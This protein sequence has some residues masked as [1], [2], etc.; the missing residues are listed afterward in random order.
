MA[1]FEY[2]PPAFVFVLAFGVCGARR[3]GCGGGG[4]RGDWQLPCL[5]QPACSPSVPPHS[6]PPPASS[7]CPSPDGC[8]KLAQVP[9]GLPQPPP[10]PLPLTPGRTLSFSL[11]VVQRASA[12][13]ASIGQTVAPF[14]VSAEP[15][16]QCQR[17]VRYSTHFKFN[18]TYRLYFNA[19]TQS[20][21]FTLNLALH[22]LYCNA[23][24]HIVSISTPHP[25]P[26]PKS[27]SNPNPIVP[28]LTPYPKLILYLK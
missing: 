8:S 1:D 23:W 7:A 12:I 10:L 17:F 22:S 3:G 16:Q 13:S 26:K 27:Y 4:G 20:Y 21:P 5:P 19:S 18:P 28:I 24:L 6:P 14:S 15:I 2:L 9:M 11:Y 25:N